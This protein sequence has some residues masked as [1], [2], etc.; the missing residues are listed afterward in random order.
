MLARDHHDYTHAE[1]FSLE[2]QADYKSEYRQGKIVAMA[3]AS[4]NHNRISGNIF[5]ALSNSLEGRPCEIFMSDLRVW[6]ERKELYT[7]PDVMVLCGDLQFISG[8]TDTITNP[9]VI[10]EVL[11]ESTAGYDRGEKFQAYWT[12]ESLEV[13]ILIE[14]DRVRVEY[15][16]RISGREWLLRV[17]TK[18]EESLII[19]SLGVEIPIER[20]YRNVSWNN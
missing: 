6:I 18:L 20:L 15:F 5:N 19:E 7:Y 16:Q 17:F 10:I 1:Y 8:R 2:E 12:L 14:Q 11:S 3:G 9:Q 13:S 4:A